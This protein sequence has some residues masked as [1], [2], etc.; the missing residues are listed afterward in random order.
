MAFE[1]LQKFIVVFVVFHPLTN[2]LLE[3]FS[4]SCLGFGTFLA[5]S[6]AFG[7]PILVLVLVFETRARLVEARAAKDE[8]IVLFAQVGVGE[9][10]VGLRDLLEYLFALIDLLLA[11][12]GLRAVLIATSQRIRMVL[13][14]KL[15]VG[16]FYVF[17]IGCGRHIQQ[18]VVASRRP[19][20]SLGLIGKKCDCHRPHKSAHCSMPSEAHS[21]HSCGLS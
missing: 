1:L 2:L 5:S 16:L 6:G 13:L 9:H 12:L 10:R 8:S 20:H 4:L 18:F 14:R 7:L 11:Q 19:S 15:V 21:A 17:R 3:L